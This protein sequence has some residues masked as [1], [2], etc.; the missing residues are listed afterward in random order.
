M[1]VSLSDAAPLVETAQGLGNGH[2][3]RESVF[4]PTQC[5]MRPVVGWAIE[6]DDDHRY[7]VSDVQAVV[8]HNGPPWLLQQWKPANG[9]RIVPHAMSLTY[10]SA[11]QQP[12]RLVAAQRADS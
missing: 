10:R 9:G 2:V 11:V 1:P 3:D 8:G 12:C 4:Q 6:R 5:V 7:Q